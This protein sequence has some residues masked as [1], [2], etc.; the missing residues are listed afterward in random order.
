MKID[1]E[2]VINKYADNEST[3]SIAKE[4]GTYPKKIERIL[5]KNNI[6]LRSKSESQKLALKAGRCEHPTKGKKRSEEKKINISELENELIIKESA[7]ND[8]GQETI[9][10][11]LEQIASEV[12][13]SA[14]IHLEDVTSTIKIVSTSDPQYKT[15]PYK[16]GQQTWGGLYNS[17]SVP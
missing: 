6:K 7:V 3:Y 10:D 12:A 14:F 15:D 16:D 1:E 11:A 4:L 8:I 9:D 2:F 5:K 17:A 13:P